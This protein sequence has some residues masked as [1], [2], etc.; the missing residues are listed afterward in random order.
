MEDIELQVWLSLVAYQKAGGVWEE[1]GSNR[2]GY[3]LPTCC[4]QAGKIQRRLQ[5]GSREC[6]RASPAP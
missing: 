3:M 2:A 5:H 1:L 6:T 4:N